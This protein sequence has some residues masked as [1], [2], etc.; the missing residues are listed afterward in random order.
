V[1]RVRGAGPEAPNGSTEW[2]HRKCQ[3]SRIASGTDTAGE[4]RRLR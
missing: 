2:A 1:G 3:W 4:R